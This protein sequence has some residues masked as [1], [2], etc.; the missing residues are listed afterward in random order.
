[1]IYFP[2]FSDHSFLVRRS[3]C[4]LCGEALSQAQQSLG[5]VSEIASGSSSV[6]A[7][8]S[9]PAALAPGRT[10]RTGGFLRG[11]KW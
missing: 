10:E 4:Q 1:M 11:N 6:A 9:S 7:A 5:S 3:G 8:K 2:Y